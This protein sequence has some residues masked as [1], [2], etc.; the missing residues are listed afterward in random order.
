MV[1]RLMRYLRSVPETLP[2]EPARDAPAQ[3]ARSTTYSQP[4]P[5]PSPSRPTG[6]AATGRSRTR[7]ARTSVDACDRRSRSRGR[8]RGDQRGDWMAVAQVP[9][10]EVDAGVRFLEEVSA[11]TA[12]VSRL[13]MCIQC[14]TCGGSCPSA[15]DMDHTPRMLFAMIR[16]GMRNR[17]CAA[18]R[19]WMC[20]SCYHCVVRCPQG[21]HIADV[22]YTL[23]GMA[24]HRQVI[25]GL[26]AARFRPRLRRSGR[27]LRAQ[28]GGRPD[29]SPLPAPLILPAA[30]HDARWAMGLFFKGR[31]GIMPHRIET[32][33]ATPRDPGSGRR[34]GAGAMSRYLYYP[35]CSMDGS[36]RSYGESLN[37]VCETLG[38]DAR[39][40]STT[41]TA[42]AP[43]S[44]SASA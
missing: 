1:G 41:G 18:T 39:R 17:C 5:N 20:V 13:E 28:L 11:K 14:G 30:S 31:I 40:R 21:V 25:S 16:A 26:H 43:P 10:P 4:R 38:L 36:G 44:T 19:P 32:A 35:G 7:Q 8:L 37:A 22:M 9:L 6:P 12:G 3:R 27:D 33:R 23:K 2:P 34:A 29:G 24:E 15:D 42:A